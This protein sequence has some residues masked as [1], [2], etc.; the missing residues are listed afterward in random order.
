MPKL[1]PNAKRMR[2]C[3]CG[4]VKIADVV[5]NGQRKKKCERCGAVKRDFPKLHSQADS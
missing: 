2:V 4:S 5:I 1:H 3:D